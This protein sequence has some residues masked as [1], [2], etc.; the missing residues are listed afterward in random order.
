[1]AAARS[2]TYVPPPRAPR[3][4]PE[5]AINNPPKRD[6]AKLELGGGLFIL[7]KTNSVGA[8]M[9]KTSIPTTARF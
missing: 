3:K 1:M 5:T 8:A 9:A 6:N 7:E 2:K 4:N